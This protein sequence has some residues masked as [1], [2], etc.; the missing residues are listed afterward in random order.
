MN[1]P[2]VGS[3]CPTAEVPP[4]I[5]EFEFENRGKILPLLPYN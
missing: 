4:G 2:M 1:F 3:P 5:A